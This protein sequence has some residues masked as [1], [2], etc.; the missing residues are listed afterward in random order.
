VRDIT[1]ALSTTT[2]RTMNLDGVAVVE[3]AGEVDLVNGGSLLAVLTAQ[4]DQHS[5]GVVVDLTRTVF[6][7]STGIA[8]LLRTA[9]QAR[10]HGTEMVVVAD[11]RAVLRP[12]QITG[13]DGELRIRPSVDLALA[14][15]AAGLAPSLP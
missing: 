2:I 3:V 4:L 9:A 8:A 15:L 10:E 7:G 12:L 6:F 5:T 13:V 14:E 1:I 11:H